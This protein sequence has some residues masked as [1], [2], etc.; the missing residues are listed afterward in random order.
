MHGVSTINYTS[1]ALE[2]VSVEPWTVHYKL[3]IDDY[4]DVVVI[5][6]VNC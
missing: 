4:K 3:R 5:V 6:T 2:N 1:Q